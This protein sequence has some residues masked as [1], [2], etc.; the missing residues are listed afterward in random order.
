MLKHETQHNTVES[1]E[2]NKLNVSP[3]LILCMLISLNYFI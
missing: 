1:A 3:K 2:S